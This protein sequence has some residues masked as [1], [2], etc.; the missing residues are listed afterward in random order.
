M[1]KKQL[2]NIGLFGILIAGG[3]FLAFQD[4]DSKSTLRDDEMAYDMAIEDTASITKIVIATRNT[5]DTATLERTDKG[6]I[7]NGQ[8]PARKGAVDELLLTFHDMELRNF[9]QESAKQ[10]IFSR[11]M[12]YGKSV[13]VYSGDEMVRDIIIGTDQNDLLGTYM[14]KRSSSTPVAMHIPKLNG[15]LSS[16]FFVR[17]YLWRDRTI[18]GWEDEDISEVIME[19]GVIPGE[20]YRIEQ[21]E[22]NKLIV[23]DASDLVIEEYDAQHTRYLLNSIRTLQYEGSIIEGEK[24]YAKMDSITSTIPVFELTVKRFDGEEKTI[25]AYHVPAAP[26]TYDDLGNPMQFDPDRFYAKISDGRFVLIQEYAFS[27]VLKTREYFIL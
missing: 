8:Y 17:E 16:R 6:W 10:T 13:R 20:S 22:D 3:L 9:P 23:H 12:G 19:Y 14:M 25:S 4:F 2:I 21:T 7:V 18:F 5:Q 24:A 26:D 1:K 15:Y 27:N 11:M